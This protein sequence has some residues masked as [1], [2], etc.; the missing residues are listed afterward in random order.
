MK[1]LLFLLLILLN[2]LLSAQT[3]EPKE[4]VATTIGFLNGGGSLFGF[5]FEFRLHKQLSAQVGM[6]LVG[7]G[8]G[9]NYHIDEDLH[10]DFFSIQYYHQG[11]GA[12]HVQSMVGPTYNFRRYDFL[13]ASI[14]IGGRVVEGQAFNQIPSQYRDVN[15]MLLYS[16]GIYKVF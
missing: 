2:G 10:S 15:V 8:A 6:G 3:D 13:A 12:G 14:G 7:F 1:N 16:L 11:A 5:D 9:L 4:D